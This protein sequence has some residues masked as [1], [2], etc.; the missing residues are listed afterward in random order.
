[1]SG[2]STLFGMNEFRLI[3]LI[4][5]TVVLIFWVVVVLWG[6]NVLLLSF[7]V[8]ASAVLWAFKCTCETSNATSPSRS[9]RLFILVTAFSLLVTKESVPDVTILPLAK[10]NPSLPT[11]DCG[12]PKDNWQSWS[13]SVGHCEILGDYRKVNV[14]AL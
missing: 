11:G 3:K 4:L 9:G 2:C 5:S 6:G 1:M 12:A 8:L 10:D 13:I 7:L 14:A